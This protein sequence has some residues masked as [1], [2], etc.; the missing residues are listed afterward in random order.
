MENARR[1]PVGVILLMVCAG[2]AVAQTVTFSSRQKGNLL[3]AG[4][5]VTGPNYIAS[6]NISPYTSDQGA[7]GYVVSW[8]TAVYGGPIPFPPPCVSPTDPPP[9]LPPLV[10]AVNVTGT[11]PL[12]LIKVSQPGVLSIDLDIPKLQTVLYASRTDCTAG[13]C[14]IS[15]PVS[16]PV[17]G[18][19]T[20]MT[21]GTG[22]STFTNSGN[23]DTV[24]I[25][26]L[27]TT[28]SSFSG[29]DS[30][31]TANFAGMIGTVAINAPPL[32]ANASMHVQKGQLRVTSVCTPP[33]PPI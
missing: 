5:S 29:T 33:P 15:Y 16:F 22:A 2:V 24:N 3:G 8:S 21:S 23:R 20:R 18:T 17:K 25:D 10:V 32:G 27:C 26:P 1:L 31:G 4:T 30:G 11:V 7:E 12:G 14:I 19:F 9:P 6:L 13:P 28:T